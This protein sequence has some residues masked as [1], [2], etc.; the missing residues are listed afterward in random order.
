MTLFANAQT[1]ASEWFTS[2]DTKYKA[3]DYAGAIKDYDKCI[4]LRPD[5][6]D[7]YFGVA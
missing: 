6:P 7:A 2:A 4:S 1:T 3:K 5:D